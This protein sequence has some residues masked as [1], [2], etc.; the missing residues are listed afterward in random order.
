M[1]T[2]YFSTKKNYHHSTLYIVQVIILHNNISDTI[3][4]IVNI[5]KW[6]RNSFMERKN[7]KNEKNE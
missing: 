1:I 2:L 3:F 5:L 7:T 6:A 4:L